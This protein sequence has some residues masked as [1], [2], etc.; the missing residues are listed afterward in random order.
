M[1][2]IEKLNMNKLQSLKDVAADV[3][4]QCADFQAKLNRDP[5]PNFV[6]KTP[7]GKAQSLTIS[8][9]ENT[10]R[11]MYNGLVQYKEFKYTQVLNEIVGT[12]EVH[13]FHPIIG[14]WM[15]YIGTASI[16]IMMNAGSDFTQLGNKKRNALYTGIPKLKSLCVKNACLLIGNIFGANLNRKFKD[17]EY[18]PDIYED[19]SDLIKAD[20]E[21]LLKSKDVPSLE[22]VRNSVGKL[23]Y[24]RLVNLK[25]YLL[26]L[27]DKKND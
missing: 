5:N 6:K 9:V 20:I 1:T 11:E 13:V 21:D 26:T 12:I 24:T 7:D 22:S 4:E 25:D 23:N 15:C 10:I 16:E 18:N 2:D 8:S 17:N 3:I 19:E 27:K 14:Q